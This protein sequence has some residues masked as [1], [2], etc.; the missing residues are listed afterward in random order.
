MLKE[1]SNLQFGEFTLNLRMRELRRNETLLPVSGKAFDLLVYMASNPGR[2]LTKSELLDAVWPELAVEESNLSQNVFLLR[3]VLGS[4]SDGPIKTLAGRGYQF[5]AEVTEVEPA[6][7]DSLPRPSVEAATQS[8]TVEAT[9]TRMIVEHDFEERISWRPTRRTKIAAAVIVVG[10]LAAGGWLFWQHWLDRSG[11]DPVK[12]VLTN[13]SGTTGDPILDRSLTDALRMDLVQSPY[14]SVVSASAIRATLTQMTHKPD[15]ALTPVTAREV[16]ERT[17]SQAV[18]SGSVAR[19]GQHFLVTEEATSCV[20]GSVLAQS[21]R[22]AENAE[23]LPHSIDKLAESLRQKLGESRRSIARFSTPLFPMN[24]VSLEAL[25]DYSQ[26]SQ[27]SAQGKWAEAIAMQKQAIAAD[28]NFAA[29]YYDL[30]AA[31]ISNGDFINGRAILQKAYAVRDNATEPVRFAINALYSQYST[32]DLYEAE[33]NNRNWVQRYPN[34]ATAWNLLSVVQ[35][36]LAHFADAT[37][38][39]KRVLALVP[40][41]QGMYANLAYHQARMGDF[42][43]AQATCDLAI[44]RH[45]D[46]DRIRNEYVGIARLLNDASMFKAQEDWANAHP[47]ATFVQFELANVAAGEGRFTDARRL[48]EKTTAAFRREGLN[49][50]AN[51]A[52]KAFGIN[53]M[54]SGDRVGGLQM[55]RSAPVDPENGNELEGLV[56]AGDSKTALAYLHAMH[57]KYPQGTL[58]NQYY[59]PHIEA[60]VA[61][62]N[63]KPQEAVTLLDAA[64]SLDNR[65]LDMPKLRADAYLAA[66][67][68]LLAE[69]EYRAV[70][71]HHQ[72]DPTLAPYPLSWLGLGRALAAQGKT[73]DAIDAYQHFLALW[74]HADPDA[75]YLKQGKQ[76]LALLQ[77]RLT[78]H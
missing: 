69:K 49:D 74:A 17:N 68:P 12:V 33:R 41:N 52:N 42:K 61:L 37:E 64:R 3:K 51:T 23:D 77:N 13:L 1:M 36:D 75:L 5:A 58:W 45:L 21:K 16:C 38:S 24:T 35:R 63:H 19:V 70:L 15:E 14:V 9:Q 71:A 20:D 55:F 31:Y 47:D 25:K 30:A 34:S 72:F 6:S 11:G 65:D 28:P 4:G 44:A 57:L 56:E 62:A 50:F 29:A 2:P 66:G 67:Q 59:G 53:L 27:L 32:E 8:I 48:M 76:E 10:I 39:S 40:G 26:A 7:P 18:L 78:A 60:L 22:E 46:G 43:G 54:E 73:K